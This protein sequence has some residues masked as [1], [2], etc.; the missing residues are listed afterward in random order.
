MP[1]YRATAEPGDLVAPE[2]WSATVRAALDEGFAYFDWLD[3]VDEVGRADELRLTLCLLDENGT[4]ALLET[5]V[6]RD[7]AEMDSLLPLIAGI[8]WSERELADLFGITFLGGDPRPLILPP[9]FGGHPLRKE[10]VVSARAATPWPGAKE[11]G[12]S[13]APSRRRMAPP[14]VPDPQVWGQRPSDADPAPA[15]E[16]AA[17]AQGGRVRSR[18]G[19]AR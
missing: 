4:E 12:E 16:V 11:P 5:T 6:P 2:Q 19:G 10:A 18:R 1:S 13:S 17:S 7:Q 9:D 8:G 3:A 15:D 14:G